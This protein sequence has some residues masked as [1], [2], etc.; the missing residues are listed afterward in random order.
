MTWLTMFIHDLHQ[1]QGQGTT[2]F[3]GAPCYFMLSIN[4]PLIIHFNWHGVVSWWIEICF[5]LP[6]FIMV[7]H[8]LWPRMVNHGWPSSFSQSVWPWSALCHLTFMVDHCQT[9]NKP[10]F[11]M[12]PI[13]EQPC[14]KHGWPW[15]NRDPGAG[16]K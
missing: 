15:S 7:K 4:C 6:W 8:V 10:W 1:L 3:H 2:L 5:S 9:I 14:S 12:V 13:H 11:T 16:E